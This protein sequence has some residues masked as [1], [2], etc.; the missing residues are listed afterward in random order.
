[1][2]A[3]EEKR[4]QIQA[5]RDC[6]HLIDDFREISRAVNHRAF[7][8][9]A[10]SRRVGFRQFYIHF[11]VGGRFNKEYGIHHVHGECPDMVG[12]WIT[13]LGCNAHHSHNGQKR[14]EFFAR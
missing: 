8:I 9:D 12:N 10:S 7:G 13:L 3:V 5:T 2:F 6:F 14:F 11:H 1:M 4:R